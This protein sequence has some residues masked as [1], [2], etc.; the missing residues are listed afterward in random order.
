M[1]RAK[2]VWMVLA[3]ALA[4][5]PLAT[6]LGSVAAAQFGNNTISGE[7]RDA[8]GK[9]F[10]DVTIIITSDKGQKWTLKTD[11]SGHF[12]QPALQSGVYFVA[13]QVKDKVIY[14]QKVALQGGAEVKADANFKEIIAKQGA[15]AAE[16]MKKQEEEK[17]KFEALKGHFDSGVAALDQAKAARTQMQQAPA[18]QRAALQ[19]KVTDLSTTAINE[20]QAAEKATGEAD[21]NRHIVFAKLGESYEAAG[22]YEEAADAYQKAIAMKS[23]QAGYYNNL[24]NVLAK[25]G[26]IQEAQAAYEKSAQLD[27]ANAAVAWRNFGIVLY[28]ANK[29][30]DAVAPLKKAT[31]LD[32]KSAQAWYLLG[33]ALVNTMEFNKEGDKLIPVVQPGTIEAYRKAIELD[34][35]GPYGA[36]A[37]QGLESL[38]AMGV[39]GID[40]KMLTRKKK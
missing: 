16:A 4:I 23:D 31:E 7:V 19:Q 22:R 29:M 12:S 37:K 6:W 28:N 34:P 15:A 13:Y 36:Q 38:Q 18:D 26:K 20:F 2:T 9:P 21:S 10:A 25:A 35:N 11:K 32:P 39:S 14:E 33:V 3:L 8:D 24:G 17:Q 30:K 5:G 1:K 27:P 40:T